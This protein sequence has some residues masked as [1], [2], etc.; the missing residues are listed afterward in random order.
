MGRVYGQG[1]EKRKREEGG[2]TEHMADTYDAELVHHL[3]RSVGGGGS[4]GKYQEKRG[5]KRK[6][7]KQK[8]KNKRDRNLSEGRRKRC[9]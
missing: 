4:D 6:Q 1:E 2:Q 7:R 8:K 9:N 3:A 5:K